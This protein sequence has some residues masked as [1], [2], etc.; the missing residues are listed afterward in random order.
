MKVGNLLL[1]MVLG[2]IGCAA[3]KVE[4]AEVKR[5]EIK[6]YFYVG[7]EELNLKKAP[8]HGSADAEK[9]KLNER[10]ER[11]EYGG[12]GWF[13]VRTEDGRQGWIIDRY[14]KVHPVSEFFVRRSGVPLKAEPEE[15]SKT[16]SR[17]RTNEQVKLLQ[18]TPEGWAEVTVARTQETGW[19]EMR[20]LSVERVVI[21][22]VRRRPAVAREEVEEVEVEEPTAP[23][24]TP[25]PLPRSPLLTPPPA[26]AE[27][28]PVKEVPSPPKVQP[29]RFEPF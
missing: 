25:A 2:L 29:E 15:R 14:L 8:D 12:A 17:L 23:P 4:V 24:E 10:V 27:P 19:L 7:A 18:Q 6:V 3:G 1:V 5:E 28:P 26:G 13:L 21:R 9:V 16:L 20:N 22:P 11:L